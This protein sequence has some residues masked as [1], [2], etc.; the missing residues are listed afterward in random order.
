MSRLAFFI[1]LYGAVSIIGF[2]L[3]VFWGKFAWARCNA[4]LHPCWK[5][6]AF[7]MATGI[8]LFIGGS[9]VNYAARTY[10]NA[11]YGLS[12]ILLRK[13]A[14][15]IGGGL[16]VMFLG[17]LVLAWLADLEDHPPMWN[18]LRA[19]IGITILWGVIVIIAV[20][21]MPFGG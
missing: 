13:E 10:G 6:R 20:P 8:A 12:M 1:F 14:W 4:V 15:F 16:A 5:D 3:T 19:A 18:Y 11:E 2:L 9:T 7:V 17:A 21:K